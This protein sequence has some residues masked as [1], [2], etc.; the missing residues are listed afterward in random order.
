MTDQTPRGSEPGSTVLDRWVDA[1]E[2]E[3]GLPP[4]TVDVGAVL[5]LARDAAHQ[6]ARPA[7]PVSTYAAGY[8][9]GLAAAGGSG[10][11]GG[12]DGADEVIR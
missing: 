4:G 3:L 9:A 10:A 11:A 7:A 8:A 2:A 1:L 5:D 12:A 6:V